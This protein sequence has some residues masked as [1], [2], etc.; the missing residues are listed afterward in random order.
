MHVAGVAD[1][2]DPSKFL[3]TL[4]LQFSKHSAKQLSSYCLK[5]RYGRLP[6]K[7]FGPIAAAACNLLARAKIV[8]CTEVRTPISPKRPLV[9]ASHGRRASASAATRAVSRTPTSKVAPLRF[10]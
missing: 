3:A 4:M 8:E 9:C 10:F 7:S 2:L 5:G 6:D 1:T